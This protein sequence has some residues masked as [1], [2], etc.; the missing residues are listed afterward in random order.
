M[1]C[2]RLI[3]FGNSL[4]DSDAFSALSSQLPGLP[5]PSALFG[6]AGRFSNGPVYADTS[7]LPNLA[8]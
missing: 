8:C 2:N 6:R 4:T 3:R 7:G 1:P 5:L